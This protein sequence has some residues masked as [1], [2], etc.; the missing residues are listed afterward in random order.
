M[1]DG[2]DEVAEEVA[3]EA[4][5]P[6]TRCWYSTCPNKTCT[7]LLLNCSSPDCE[8]QF[9]GACCKDWN[10]TR[11][12]PDELPML[13]V[14]CSEGEHPQELP[15]AAAGAAAIGEEEPMGPS[16]P[17]V[18]EEGAPAEGDIA[19]PFNL[20]DHVSF[21]HGDGGGTPSVIIKIDKGNI[22]HCP[23]DCSSWSAT[24]SVEFAA[25]AVRLDSNVVTLNTIRRALFDK[26]KA[27][28]MSKF[29]MP[30]GFLCGGLYEHGGWTLSTHFNLPSPGKR[31]SVRACVC[32]CV[33]VR[34]CV[35]ACVR[36]CVCVCVCRFLCG[37]L[38]MH[39]G[40]TVCTHFPLPAPGETS[41]ARFASSLMGF[42]VGQGQTASVTPPLTS[43]SKEYT[44][45]SQSEGTAVDT[46]F[47]GIGTGQMGDGDNNQNRRF[48][49]VMW[50]GVVCA[51][52]FNAI[53]NVVGD[54]SSSTVVNTDL[55]AAL[56]SRTPAALHTAAAASRRRFARR[57][58][59]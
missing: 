24:P 19:R 46:E 43:V 20:W 37:G 8:E 35:R 32:E 21:K 31:A 10:Q 5:V 14:N 51:V 54:V 1:E 18:V 50:G 57:N 44:L 27:G 23:Y 45:P 38:Y 17:V 9:H 58:V 26:G 4:A 41:V 47:L 22:M 3:D 59:P 16:P 42:S 12:L 33:C 13:C 48:V 49:M 11:E 30:S 28:P 34:A 52:Y 15:A 25:T 40:W 56:S 36:V 39:E 2:A 55:I 6:A 53:V 7:L 29:W